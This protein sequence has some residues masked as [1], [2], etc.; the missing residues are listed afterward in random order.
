MKLNHYLFSTPIRFD[1][2]PV[3]RLVIEEPGEFGR[4]IDELYSQIQGYDGRFTVSENTKIL[5][6][7]KYAHIIIDP[8]SITCNSKD[9]IAGLHKTIA[10]E[11]ECGEHYLAVRTALSELTNRV[12]EVSTGIETG[13]CS[14]E[15]TVQ[16]LLKALSVGLLEPDSLAERICEF[17]RLMF[18]YSSKKLAIAVNLRRFLDEEEYD[19]TIR[20]LVYC[21]TPV[22]LIE[23]C[24]KS[25]GID[26]KIIDFDYCEVDIGPQRNI[27]EV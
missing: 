19:E 6:L 16:T 8:F 12:M 5:E 2:N 24:A 20:Q 17:I 18:T 13:C 22:L 9:I 1:E 10:K 25:D 26:S 21:Q 15:A 11:L 4:I 14:E 23:D 7:S 3:Q 27:F